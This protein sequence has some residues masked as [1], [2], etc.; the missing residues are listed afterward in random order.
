MKDEPNY[1]EYMAMDDSIPERD[2]TDAKVDAPDGKRPF[3]RKG[4][5]KGGKKGWRKKGAKKKSAKKA[6]RKR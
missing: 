4:T 3:P 6:S 2:K 1:D 5:R